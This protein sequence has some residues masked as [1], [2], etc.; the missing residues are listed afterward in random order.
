MWHYG[1][2]NLYLRTASLT[3]SYSC[4]CPL[5]MVLFPCYTF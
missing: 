4:R 5:E 3:T 2:N 1:Q